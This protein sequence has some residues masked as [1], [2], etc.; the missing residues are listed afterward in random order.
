[1]E[2]KL[3]VRFLKEKR[4][5]A[6]TLVVEEYAPLIFAMSHA[7]A[8]VIIQEDLA[9]ESGVPVA[10]NYFSLVRAIATYKKKN[11]QP[12]T[13]VVKLKHEF[14]DAHELKEG[15]PEPIVFNLPKKN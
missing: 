7:M 15:Q 14:K 9:K 2:K 6:Y 5:G 12:A 4:R 10:L 1:M 13:R 11:P 8:L 3:I